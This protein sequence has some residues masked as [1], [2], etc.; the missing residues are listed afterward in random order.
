MALMSVYHFEIF[1]TDK[2]VSAQLQRVSP[3]RLFYAL[4]LFIVHI[5]GHT[6]CKY[7]Q[8][9]PCSYLIGRVYRIVLHWIE[10]GSIL[11]TQSGET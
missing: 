2:E 10:L 3:R 4:E 1:A 11:V 6:K 8:L 9:Q 5:T 7:G